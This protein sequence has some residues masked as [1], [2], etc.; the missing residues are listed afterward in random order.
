[1]W[2]REAFCAALAAL[3]FAAV[4]R[5][6]RPGRRAGLV[7]AAIAAPLFGMWVLAAA[8]WILAAPQERADLLFGQTASVCPFL[9]A[10]LSA[11]LFLALIWVMRGLAPTQLRLAGGVGGFAAGAMGA[12]VYSLHCPELAAPF[13]GIWYVLGMLIPTAVGAA[14]GPWLLRW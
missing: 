10:L 2:L 3:G 14:L 12:L 6:C 1:F 13:L 11:P 4:A 9:I 7:P 8:S 5:V